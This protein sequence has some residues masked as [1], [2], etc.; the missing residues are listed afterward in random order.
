MKHLS[1][2]KTVVPENKEEDY[3]VWSEYISMQCSQHRE[4]DHQKVKQMLINNFK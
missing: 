1:T 4:S 3:K 2:Q